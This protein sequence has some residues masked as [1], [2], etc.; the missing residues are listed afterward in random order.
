MTII[1]YIRPVTKNRRI[2]FLIYD[3]FELLDLSGPASVFTAANSVGR[4]RSYEIKIISAEGGEICSSA[5]LQMASEKLAKITPGKTD[6]VLVVGAEGRAITTAMA[7]ATVTDWLKKAAKTVER[8]GSVC[9]GA[10]IAAAAGLLDNHKATTHWAGCKRLARAFPSVYVEADALYVV[11]ARLWTSAGVTTGIDMALAMIERDHGSALMGQIAK[12]LVV[13]AHR[14]GNQSQFSSVL[15]A[16]SAAG[17]AFAGVISWIGDNLDQAVRLEDLA[18]RAGMSERTFRRKFT[19]HVGQSPSKFLE[20]L[21]LDKAKGLLEAKLPVAAVA[22]MVGF[23]SEAGFRAAFQRSFG[24][25]PSMHAV[26]HAN[27]P[28]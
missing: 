23:R 9:S 22:S 14:P 28:G 16:Q 26:I 1:D 21:R 5:G 27:D 20:S 10:F 17:G 18:D 12:W 8:Y 24:I 11:D 2:L 6:T 13:Y 3:G 7:D 4:R 15:E 19:E 25:S